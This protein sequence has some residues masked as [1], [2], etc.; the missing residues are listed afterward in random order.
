ME[1]RGDEASMDQCTAVVPF[2]FSFIALLPYLHTQEYLERYYML[3]AF[4]GYLQSAQFDP[5]SSSHVRFPEWM[6]HRVEL[7]R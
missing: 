3:I 7:R 4:T 5:G 2:Y 1:E 6:V